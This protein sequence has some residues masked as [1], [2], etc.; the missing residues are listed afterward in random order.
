M[1][2]ITDAEIDRLCKSITT[3]DQS[4]LDGL[5]GR[6][7]VAY[8]KAHE[9][10]VRRLARLVWE[11]FPLGPRWWKITTALKRVYPKNDAIRARAAEIG[12]LRASGHIVQIGYDLVQVS[13]PN[14]A[15]TS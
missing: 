15:G 4:E 9:A 10:D 2:K 1:A 3:W 5:I 14:M 8:A 7:A 6:R 11:V 13:T 12:R